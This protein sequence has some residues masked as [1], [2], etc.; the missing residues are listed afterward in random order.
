M[1]FTTKDTEDTT[2]KNIFRE[3][4]LLCGSKIPGAKSLGKGF[5]L[6]VMKL[7]FGFWEAPWK[8]LK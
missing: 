2:P 4:N 3:L 5:G 7:L 6:M 8:N 1:F